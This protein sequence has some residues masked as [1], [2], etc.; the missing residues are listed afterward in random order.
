MLQQECLEI[1]Q[2]LKTVINNFQIS[3]KNQPQ[4]KQLLEEVNNFYSL[5]GKYYFT[6]YQLNS[7]LTLNMNQNSSKMQKHE[8]KRPIMQSYLFLMKAE[9]AFGLAEN[10]EKKSLCQEVKK[11]LR[12][13]IQS[14]NHISEKTNIENP[15]LRKFT[16][17]KQEPFIIFD[18]PYFLKEAYEKNEMDDAVSWLKEL[19]TNSFSPH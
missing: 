16:F 11:N 9:E 8:L 13:A 3:L 19:K 4:D 10:V 5:L 1:I 15:N 18:G 14:K 6:Y 7:F 17:F 12:L 2:I